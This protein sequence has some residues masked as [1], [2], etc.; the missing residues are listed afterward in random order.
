MTFIIENQ[1]DQSVVRGAVTV[2]VPPVSS[3]SNIQTLHAVMGL[4]LPKEADMTFNKGVA[5]VLC[6]YGN[7]GHKRRITSNTTA[8]PFLTIFWPAVHAFISITIAQQPT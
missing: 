8:A 6:S 4:P 5:M 2:N 1:E 3:L 7:D